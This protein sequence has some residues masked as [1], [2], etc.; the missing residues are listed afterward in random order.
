MKISTIQEVLTP[1]VGLPLR[2]FGRAANLLWI[3][4]GKI[5][6]VPA[7]GGGTKNVGEWALHV[8]CPWRLC[9]PGRVVIAYHDFY[10]TPECKLL[11]NWD[12]FG[13]SQFDFVATKLAEEFENNPPVVTSGQADDVGGFSI[14]MS[15]QYRLEVFVDE[16]NATA[17]QWRLFQPAIDSRHFVFPAK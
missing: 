15:G 12:E 5:R 9:Q 8:Q 17:E 6:E 10:H 2:Y 4:F 16:S 3:H 7:Y 14:E 13:K 11:D 1:L